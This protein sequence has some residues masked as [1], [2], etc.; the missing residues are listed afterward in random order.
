[1]LLDAVIQFRLAMLLDAVIQSGEFRQTTLVNHK[2]W[3]WACCKSVRW[4]HKIPL[5]CPVPPNLKFRY[6]IR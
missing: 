6:L 1:M 2:L 3:H 5:V 4:V